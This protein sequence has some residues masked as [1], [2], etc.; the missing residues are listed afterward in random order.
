MTLPEQAAAGSQLSSHSGSRLSGTALNRDAG[1][2]HPPRHPRPGRGTPHTLGAAGA[3]V[4]G[5]AD[6]RA[7]HRVTGSSSAAV[8]RAV[9]VKSEEARRTGCE[10]E[11]VR[12]QGWSQGEEAP[13][14]RAQLSAY[15][16]RS[17]KLPLQPG[18]QVQAPLTWSQAAPC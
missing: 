13:R 9:A 5:R 12:G 2:L 10:T 4:A 3:P 8:A 6:A 15:S 14:P 18:W 1:C 7:V 11:V 17:Q 16:P